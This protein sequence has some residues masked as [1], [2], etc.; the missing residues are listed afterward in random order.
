MEEVGVND[1]VVDGRQR[2]DERRTHKVSEGCVV[3]TGVEAGVNPETRDN[4]LLGV[5]LDSSANILL[6]VACHSM[7]KPLGHVTTTPLAFA[8]ERFSGLVHFDSFVLTPPD[9]VFSLVSELS[10]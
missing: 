7:E 5:D 8:R 1:W 4:L 6:L 9:L 2:N 10:F 3:H